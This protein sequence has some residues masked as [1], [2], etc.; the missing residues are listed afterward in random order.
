MLVFCKTCNK[1]FDKKLC[2][3]K[4]NSNNFCSRSC[5][6]KHNNL[7]KQKNKPKVRICKGC[8]KDFIRTNNILTE[9]CSECREH[10]KQNPNKRK[11][12]NLQKIL[13]SGI[14]RCCCCKQ[15]KELSNFTSKNG[16]IQ[17]YCKKCSSDYKVERLRKIKQQ[18]V[19]YKGGKC[20]RCEYDKYIGALEFHH[21]DP[22]QKDFSLSRSNKLVFNE[23]VK[24][25]LD[26]CILLCANCHREEHD[27]IRNE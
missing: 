25:E 17:K 22:S 19:D 8:Q 16:R 4:R 7:G 23:L 26:K 12:E 5:S 11:L 27:R 6:A 10:R 18:A 1:E 20:E 24:N 9:Y 15:T 14:M 13:D 3:I 21:L 2:E